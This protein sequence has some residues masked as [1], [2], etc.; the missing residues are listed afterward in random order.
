MASI[1]LNLL[2]I[3]LPSQYGLHFWPSWAS[4]N[5]LRVDYFSP[6]LYFTDILVFLLF[7]SEISKF[8]STDWSW[9]KSNVAFWL[10]Q[11]IFL[12]VYF[13]VSR[14]LSPL[15]SA[16][17]WA[18]IAEFAFL[19]YYISRVRLN[20][21]L[22]LIPILFSSVLTI[23]Q[24]INQ[25]S[26]GGLWYFLGER[27]F[28]SL[29]PGI[30]NAFINGQL[31]LRPYATFPHPNVLAGFLAVI[32]PLIL[33]RL[34][35]ISRRLTAFILALG[36]VALFLT[37]SRSAIVV[38]LLATA[39]ILKFKPI[40]LVL[41]IAIILLSPRLLSL[42]FEAE[43]LLVRTEQI[44][45]SVKEF[46][47]SPIVGTGLGT[48]PLYLPTSTYNYSLAHQP[49]HNIYLLLL[50]ETG[51][52]GFGLFIVL[53]VIA[54]K[55]GLR[56]RRIILVPLFSILAIGLL[57]HYFLTLQQT[58]LLFAIILGNVFAFQQNRL[59]HRHPASR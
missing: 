42:Q 46:A 5:G 32:L 19:A 39:V 51:S 57:D 31:L 3:F 11:I 13:N 41:V 47:S 34:T 15:V 44:N 23:C 52:F 45:L 53:I 14:S 26:I 10:F 18:K 29:T 22:L 12:L 28:T 21:K 40:I 58:Q 43:P 27:T 1:L 7:I 50:S 54:I 4:I 36:Y 37:L 20:Y 6:T 35:H 25:S 48:S 30:A 8:K 33:A 38:G 9:T 24:F 55:N 16:Y 17:K 49:I 56:Q 2:L 59:E